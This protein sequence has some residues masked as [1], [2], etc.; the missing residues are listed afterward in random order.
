MYYM[1]NY[2]PDPGTCS[3]RVQT[4]A[5]EN[6]QATNLTSDEPVILSTDPKPRL[7]WTRD[8]HERFVD[9]VTQLG[10]AERAT[11]KSVMRVMNVKGLTLYHLKSHLQKYRLGK[12]SQ[13]D[14][15]AGGATNTGNHVEPL[16]CPVDANFKPMD[17]GTKDLNQSSPRIKTTLSLMS[18]PDVSSENMQVN[19][20]IG[21]HIEVQRKLHEQLEVQRL[22]Q[23]RIEAQGRYLQSILEKAKQTLACEDPASTGLEAARAELS[24][25][26]SKVS[27]G[28]FYLRGSIPGTNADDFRVRRAPDEKVK[29]SPDSCVTSINHNEKLETAGSKI[30]TQFSRRKRLKGMEYEAQLRQDVEDLNL[31]YESTSNQGEAI[32]GEQACATLQYMERTK[33]RGGESPVDLVIGRVASRHTNRITGSEATLKMDAAD[34]RMVKGIDLNMENDGIGS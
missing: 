34:S 14:P 3:Y 27:A 1:E 18:H 16:K 6:H 17:P 8:L 26:A 7:R 12:Q 29:C 9:A 32:K 31:G 5:E 4:F 28:C 22:L 24:D 2:G 20:A 13:R 11:P 25:L 15:C 19:D 10:G 23:V 33:P 30:D 21:F